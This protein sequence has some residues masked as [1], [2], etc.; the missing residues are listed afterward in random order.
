METEIVVEEEEKK[1]PFVLAGAGSRLISYLIDW[2]IFVMISV[3]LVNVMI[4]TSYDVN[5]AMIVAFL[6]VLVSVA[7]FTYFFGNG[8]TPGMM[9]MKIKLIGIDG[10]YPIGYGKASSG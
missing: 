10:T 3:T 7:Y 8:Q 1:M 9:A 5:V 4:L 2:L 6:Y